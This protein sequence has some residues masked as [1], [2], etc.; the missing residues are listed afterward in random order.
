MNWKGY[1]RKQSWLNLKYYTGIWLEELRKIQKNLWIAV[2][3]PSFALGTS[4][5]QSRLTAARPRQHGVK[6]AVV[7]Y[8]N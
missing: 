6:I 4:E 2:Y 5:I 1:G 7:Q 3:G 8:E